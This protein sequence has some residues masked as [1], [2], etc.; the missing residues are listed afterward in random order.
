MPKNK[1]VAMFAQ[2]QTTCNL[3]INIFQWTNLK[4]KILQNPFFFFTWI[5]FKLIDLKLALHVWKWNT[6]KLQLKTEW[7]VQWQVNKKRKTMN[8]RDKKSSIGF[9]RVNACP[10][11]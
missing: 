11:K 10:Q 4:F 3:L 2:I 6:T 1:M 5:E 7:N 9:K 8:K